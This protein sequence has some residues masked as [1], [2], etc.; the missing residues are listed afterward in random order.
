[1]LKIFTLQIEIDNAA[2]EDTGEE[3]ASILSVAAAKV[4]LAPHEP[5]ILRDSNGNRVG[6]H[7]TSTRRIRVCK[8]K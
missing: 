7:R 4:R 5:G 6:F 1:M 3:L 8:L 2:F